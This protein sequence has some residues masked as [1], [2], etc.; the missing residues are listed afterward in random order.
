[1][2]LKNYVKVFEIRNS[3]TVF[4]IYQI[5]MSYERI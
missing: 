4:Q 3:T 2:D 5:Q 1:M